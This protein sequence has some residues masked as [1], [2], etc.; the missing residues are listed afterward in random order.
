MEEFSV[1]RYL[2][3]TGT[4]LQNNLKGIYIPFYYIFMKKNFI[5]IILQL[6]C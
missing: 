5:K 4:P 1:A 3:L 6:F 2:L